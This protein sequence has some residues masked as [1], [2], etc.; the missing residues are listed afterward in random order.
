MLPVNLLHYR[1]FQPLSQ[2]LFLGNGG[3]TGLVEYIR[4]SPDT[5]CRPAMFLFHARMVTP[6][7][8]K[9][10]GL[11]KV[12]GGTFKRV[13]LSGNLLDTIQNPYSAPYNWI[14]ILSRTYPGLRWSPD[15]DLYEVMQGHLEGVPSG[16]K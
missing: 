14:G 4:V 15:T 7:A 6:T 10:K 1:L 8:P 5:C 12:K 16:G 13:Y 3:D 2:G 11:V 9:V